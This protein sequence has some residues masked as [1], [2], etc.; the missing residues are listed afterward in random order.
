[1]SMESGASVRDR[2]GPPAISVALVT[3]NRP[4][5]VQRTLA[6][7]APQ[8]EHVH[9]VVLSDDSDPPA[10]ADVRALAERHGCRYLEG[11]RRGL[12]ANRNAAALACTGTH[13]RTMDDDHE[14]PP[15]HFE[16]CVEAVTAEPE[17]IWIIGEER[18]GD[19]TSDT[20]M[21]P[22][23]LHPRGYSVP[24]RDGEPCW[25]ISDGATIYPRGV[26]DA[27][28]RLL[29]SFT[30]GAA[31]LEWGSR[32]HWL[33]YRIRH[34]TGTWVI[35][36]YDPGARSYADPRM[37]LASRVLASAMHS[38]VYQPSAR[39]R[40]LTVGEVVQQVVRR[41]RVAIPAARMAARAYRREARPML[42]ALR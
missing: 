35:H 1:M 11:P 20:A 23:Q 30:F 13:V 2:A 36:H 32:L 17:T 7:L 14:F 41:P 26:F 16:R 40:A 25:A 5:S 37:E 4:S 18:P 15:G 22:P 8:R 9:D 21:P 33:G 12:Y 38:F 28:H 24:P 3:R 10:A 27:G 34:L 31:Y 42:R 19:P 29:E 6:S 39:N